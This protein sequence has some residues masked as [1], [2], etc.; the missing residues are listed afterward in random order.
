[1]KKYILYLGRW[2]LSTPILAGVFAFSFFENL[3]PIEKSVIA[4]TI[5]GFIFF[6]VDRWI[7][8]NKEKINEEK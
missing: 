8:R 2:Q 3:G 6:W 4:N 1:M 5:G 7:F